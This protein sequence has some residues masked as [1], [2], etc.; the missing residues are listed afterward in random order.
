MEHISEILKQILDRN[1]KVEADK[2]WETS[3]LRRVFV[4]GLTYIV[5]AVFMVVAGVGRPWVSALVPTAGYILST[6]TL[7]PLKKWWIKNH[8]QNKNEKT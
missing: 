7:P 3:F 1:Q 6:L 2:A 5:L 4:S 8:Y